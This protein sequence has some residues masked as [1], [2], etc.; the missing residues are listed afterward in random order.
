MKQL[1]LSILIFWGVTAGKVLSKWIT[2]EVA[3]I[4]K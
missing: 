2:N 4:M 1:L 3:P